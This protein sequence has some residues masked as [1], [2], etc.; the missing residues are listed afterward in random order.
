LVIKLTERIEADTSSYRGLLLSNR[1][2]EKTYP[3]PSRRLS[4]GS[5]ERMYTIPIPN[6]CLPTTNG[7]YLHIHHILSVCLRVP[8]SEDVKLPLV[9]V[10]WPRRCE[11]DS[12]YD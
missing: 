7:K 5:G 1:L 3:L 8:G 6:Q 4:L 2:F 10:I 11:Q 12:D 9:L